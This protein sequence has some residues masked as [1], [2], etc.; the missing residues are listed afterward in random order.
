MGKLKTAFLCTMWNQVLHRLKVLHYKLWSW[1]CAMLLICWG[2]CRNL[3]LVWEMSLMCLR[4]KQ[5]QCL[6]EFQQHR[7]KT[8]KDKEN[9][10]FMLVNLQHL[11]FTC[12]E[13]KSSHLVCYWLWWIGCWMNLI[14]IFSPMM[15]STAFSAFNFL[16]NIS[17]LS[18]EHLCKKYAYLQGRYHTDL[19][20]NFVKKSSSLKTSSDMMSHHLQGNFY[21]ALEK[22]NYRPSSKMWML[23]SDFT[24][25]YQSWMQVG[26]TVSP[27]WD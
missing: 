15:T 8:H 27:K 23:L 13:D 6:P 24:W 11:R 3:L 21:F 9:T 2:H 25:H 4:P 26:S 1:T 19:W 7:N 20:R 10:R 17:I 18:A 5:K 22:E 16:N 12:Q 14:G